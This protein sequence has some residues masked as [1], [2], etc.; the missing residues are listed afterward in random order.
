VVASLVSST[1]KC[2]LYSANIHL[3]LVRCKAFGDIGAHSNR[4]AE[5]EY[6]DWWK[7][8]LKA[9]AAPARLEAIR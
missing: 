4:E 1:R 5:K 6:P 3:I 2:S 7:E 8:I 9:V